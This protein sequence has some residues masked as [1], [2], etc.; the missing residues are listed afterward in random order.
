MRLKHTGH[1]CLPRVWPGRATAAAGE[2]G[3]EGE[4]AWYERMFAVAPGLGRVRARPAGVEADLLDGLAGTA[5]DRAMVQVLNDADPRWRWWV[6]A[7]R[8]FQRHA[9]AYAVRRGVRQV[10]DLGCGYATATGSAYTWVCEWED[11][12][13]GGRLAY[14]GVDA[15]PIVAHTLDR[16]MRTVPHHAS[17]QADIDDI[18]SVLTLLRLAGRPLDFG[19]PMLIVAAGVFQHVADPG[20][21]LG[22]LRRQVAAGTILAVSHP[23]LPDPASIVLCAAVDRYRDEVAPWYPRPADTA[24]GMLDGWEVPAGGV[25]P[26]GR[27]RAPA[28]SGT[29]HE[30]VLEEI[31]DA[32]GWAVLAIAGPASATGQS[33]AARGGPA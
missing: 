22:R 30:P 31:A 28:P 16:H 4:G 32:P 11:R 19:A 8:E 12:N 29:E 3:T 10:L 14:Q 25:M 6:A 21:I 18:D 26:V 2:P 7:H 24:A 13:P 33:G 5:A 17:L 1:L 20:L 27:W 9:L 23:D 15:D